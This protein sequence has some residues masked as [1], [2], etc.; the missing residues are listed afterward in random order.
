[1]WRLIVEVR[2]YRRR[3]RVCP[4]V[5]P[6]VC[7]AVCPPGTEPAAGR[8]ETRLTPSPGPT[9]YRRRVDYPRKASG[10]NI[11]CIIHPHHQYALVAEAQGAAQ[12]HPHHQ[13][14]LDGGTPPPLVFYG[15]KL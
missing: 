12:G 7:P 15:Q 5:C 6:A 4:R 14:A 3:P 1:M 10:N 2:C 11:E 13:Y 9:R 8:C